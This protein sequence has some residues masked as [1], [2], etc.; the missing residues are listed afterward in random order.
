M[1][2][3]IHILI[4]INWLLFRK[5]KMVHETMDLQQSVVKPIGERK[6][7]QKN[8]SARGSVLD[9][10]PEP[11]TDEVT[12]EEQGGC[13]HKK[14]KSKKVKGPISEEADIGKEAQKKEKR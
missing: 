8:K 12:P 5:L 10:G 3:A 13:S 9:G 4:R 6:A 1:G 2:D 7:P 14:K 11:G